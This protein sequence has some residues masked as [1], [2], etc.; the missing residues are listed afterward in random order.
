MNVRDLRR[1]LGHRRQR[2]RFPRYPG[3]TAAC[4]DELAL[5]ADRR[6]GDLDR[7]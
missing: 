3:V 1:V 4:R 5:I 7:Y 2:R 6:R